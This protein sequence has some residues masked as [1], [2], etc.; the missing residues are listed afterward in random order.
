MFGLPSSGVGKTDGGG[1]VFVDAVFFFFCLFVLFR[2]CR[3][4]KEGR[5]IRMETKREEVEGGP[6]G[7]SEW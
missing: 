3:E 4:R 2:M 6:D 5:E 7:R 1:H